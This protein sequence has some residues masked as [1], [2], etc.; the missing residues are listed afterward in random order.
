MLKLDDARARLAAL[1]LGQGPRAGHLHRLARR[2]GEFLLACSAD[3]LGTTLKRLSMFV[4]RAKCKLSDA[5][6]ELPVHGLAGPAAS[7]WL[8]APLAPWE[9]RRLG[10]ATALRLS[11]ACGTARYL[12][13]GRQPPPLAA[14][15]P[16]GL[17]TGSKCTA[18]CR[19]WLLRPASSS[20]RRC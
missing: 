20:C 6:G 19:A 12:S 8:G 11:D 17:A 16:P 3:L 4:L 14:L 10:E 15:P 9:L 7:A 18:A 5:S 2:A 13:V 1:L